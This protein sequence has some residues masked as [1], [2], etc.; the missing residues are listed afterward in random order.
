MDRRSL[1]KN[2]IGP[3]LTGWVFIAC[4]GIAP[5]NTNIAV[6]G[7]EVAPLVAQALDYT[8]NPIDISNP[9]RGFY[10]P[11]TYVIPVVSGT[12]G[13]PDLTAT[14][15][16]TSVSVNSSI[17]YMEFDLKHF[18]SN[19]PLNGKPMGPWS[20][21][22]ALP[23]E[24]GTT[25]ALTPA[26]L[27]YV[28]AALQLVRESETVAIVK[29]NYDGR[30]HTYVDRGS[31][32]QGIHD[33]EPG[34]PEGRVWYETGVREE[35]DL[36]GIA[37]HEEKNWIQFHLWQLGTIFSEFEECIMVVKGGIFGPWGEMH[38]S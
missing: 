1:L 2:T 37:G 20:A 4:V 6:G 10:R 30:G 7:R 32:D 33:C 12:P 35:S 34:A 21:E 27:D 24:Y 14:I 22:D 19:A 3:L 29:F 16:G 38:S 31:F 18:S 8:E 26:A 36:C 17:V 15:S 11:Q 9:D 28:R 13:F 25:Q 23:P 5:G